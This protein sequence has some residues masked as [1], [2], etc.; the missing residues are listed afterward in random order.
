MSTTG[1][2]YTGT[3]IDVTYIPRRC[4]HAA[5]CVRGLRAV[6]DTEKRPWID[7]DAAS[8]DEV[9]AVVRR[10]PSGALHFERR[11]GGSAEAPPAPNRIVVTDAGPYRLV[12]DL[13]LV[14]SD[15]SELAETRATLCRCGASQNK[16]FCDNSHRTIGFQPEPAPTTD[17]PAEPTADGILEVQPMRDG[18]LIV[19]GSVGVWDSA[20]RRV[21]QGERQKLWLCRCGHSGRK[22]FCDGSHGT[23]GF[24]AE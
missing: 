14:G 2:R 6:F 13:R 16:P 8:A 22:P 18:P 19:H 15:G 7:P 5:E 1:R 24:R 9:A 21:V 23:V 12:G 4:I 3:A 10:C 17:E 11:D 20:G